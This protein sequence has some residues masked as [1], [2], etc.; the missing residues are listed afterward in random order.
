MYWKASAKDNPEV[1][2]KNGKKLFEN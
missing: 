1:I 2:Q